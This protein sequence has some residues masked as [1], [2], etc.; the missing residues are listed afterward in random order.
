MEKNMEKIYQADP[1]LQNHSDIKFAKLD[2]YR[3]LS[4][5]V[6]TF[7]NLFLF[8]RILIF[9]PFSEHVLTCPNLICFSG[10]IL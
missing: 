2:M 1:C 7:P 4:K 10:T 9:A 8:S 6:L 5:Y 3:H